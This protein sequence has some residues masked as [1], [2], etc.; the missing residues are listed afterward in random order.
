MLL[1]TTV[2]AYTQVELGDLEDQLPHRTLIQALSQTSLMIY[3]MMKLHMTKKR[4]KMT[5]ISL[6]VPKKAVQQTQIV[7]ISMSQKTQRESILP[8]NLA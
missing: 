8:S 6:L 7:K 4:S 5:I 1:K 3:L 2:D